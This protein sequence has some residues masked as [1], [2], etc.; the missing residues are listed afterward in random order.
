M[1]AM[2]EMDDEQTEKMLGMLR[3]TLP[4]QVD[5]GPEVVIDGVR[6]FFR[7]RRR[8]REISNKRRECRALTK[9]KK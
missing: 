2:L 5:G 6:R 1:E 4:K 3:S 7:E 8:E 9:V